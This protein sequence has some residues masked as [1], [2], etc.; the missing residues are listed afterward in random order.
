VT[1]ARGEGGGS[2]AENPSPRIGSHGAWRCGQYELSLARPLVMGILNVTADSFSDG[3]LYDNPLAAVSHGE[4]LVREG[5]AILDVGGESTRPGAQPVAV[6]AELS[7]VR[8][9]VSR[10]ASEGL[11]VSIDTRRAEVASACIESGASILNDVSGFRDPAMIEVAAATDVG[12]IVMH[13]LGEPQSMQD[14]PRYDDVVGEVRAYLAGQAAILEAAGV[15]RERI[16]IDPG[17]GFG[18]TFEHNL[19]LLRRLPEL[20]DLGYPVVVGASRKRFIGEATAVDQPAERLGGSVATALYAADRGAAVLRVH[21]VAPTVQAL[22]MH[23][24][25]LGE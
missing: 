12:L 10:I 5:A 18:K 9:I 14:D 11:P 22:R 4:R 15:A 25:L 16:A 21:D 17:L 19:E 8:P 2:T 23:A 24:A 1:E 3:G 13:M 20:V 6:G 7:A